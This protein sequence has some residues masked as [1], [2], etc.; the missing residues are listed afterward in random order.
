MTVL[1]LAKSFQA[2]H[3]ASLKNLSEKNQFKFYIKNDKAFI[4]LIKSIKT[5]LAEDQY[6]VIRGLINGSEDFFEV[7]IEEFGIYYGVIERTG[8]KLDCD[9]TGCNRKA[10]NLHNDDAIDLDNQ[11]KFGF[12]QVTK[13]DPVMK[14]SNGVVVIKEL[15]SKLKYENQKLL[16]ELLTTSV[17]MLSYGVNYVSD[18]RDEIIINQPILYKKDGTYQVRFDDSRVAHFYYKKGLKQSYQELNMIESF[19]KAAHE[20]KHKYY[21]ECGD[22][23]I[24]NNLTTLHDRSECSLEINED[25]SFDSR[26]IMVSFARDG[27]HK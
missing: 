16:D 11:P 3:L 9:Y 7:F 22:I 17:P 8:I 6:I 14:V 23:L 1:A 20:I 13:T 19:V 2:N 21:L 27:L 25:G 5:I 26:E 12:I 10:L 24:Q 18:Q 15:V 4:N